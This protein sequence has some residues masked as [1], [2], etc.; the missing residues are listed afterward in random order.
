M[1]DL[2]IGLPTW[3]LTR[4]FGIAAY[5]LLFAGMALGILYS[6]P[7]VKGKRKPAI[8]KTHM[9]LTNSGSLL[10]LLHAA[11][12]VI[13]TYTPFE[14]K[15]ILIPFMAHEHPVL[16]G[17]GTISLYGLILLLLT[18]DFRQKLSKG[19]WLTI[20]LLAYPIFMLAMAHG[21]FAG[22]D[23]QLPAMKWMYGA[24]IAITL[25]L[26]GGRVLLR[27]PLRRMTA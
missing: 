20:H 14:W 21:F 27:K 11:V 1:T 17:M 7:F 6:Y 8:Y 16:Y 23:S 9:R 13:D 19:L 18:S 3:Q 15:E 2:I 25:M 12:L 5:L 4:I 24:T 10:A 22:T 26:L